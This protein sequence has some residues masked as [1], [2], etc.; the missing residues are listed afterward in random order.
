M[1]IF[2]NQIIKIV[3]RYPWFMETSLFKKVMFVFPNKIARRYDST[4]GSR[5]YYENPLH[6][7]LLNLNFDS[8]FNGKI[9]D[10]CTGTGFVP[11]TAGKIFP[12][13][14]I[15]GIDQSQTMLDIAK[16]K[17]DFNN[18]HNVEFIKEDA[19]NLSFEDDTFDLVTVSNA[20]FYFDQIIRVLKPSG[21]FLISLSF[22]GKGIITNRK[23]IEEFFLQH[24]L[25]VKEVTLVEKGAFILSSLNK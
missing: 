22:G 15:F 12:D 16:N 17:A 3:I 21:H 14:K 9:L 1:S 5:Q 11:L 10:L 20:P 6:E 2:I 13:A 19:S 8:D 7:G 25:K 23:R 4:V 18:I 24:K